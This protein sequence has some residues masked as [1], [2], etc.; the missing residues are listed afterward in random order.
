ME[1]EEAR[2]AAESS[3]D[4][5]E[6][7]KRYI[8]SMR[9]E[10]VR[11]KASCHVVASLCLLRSAINMI[12]NTE[13][14]RHVTCGSA[15]KRTF[16]LS[17]GK[18]VPASTAYFA[19]KLEFL[20]YD[21]LYSNYHQGKQHSQ[22]PIFFHGQCF[23]APD[24]PLL[25]SLRTIS[26]SLSIKTCRSEGSASKRL[27]TK[28]YQLFLVSWF[29]I[30]FWNLMILTDQSSLDTFVVKAKKQPPVTKAILREFLLEVIVDAD[31]VSIH[32]KIYSPWWRYP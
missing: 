9:K 23:C 24:T 25:F 5:D 31:L 13:T 8:K 7:T 11:V 20:S 14:N 27:E 6:G 15:L 12:R 28:G 3:D 2:L 22:V 10:D 19:C 1:D 30:E 26:Q 21:K 4:N 32:S 16:V 29:F 18:S 17:M